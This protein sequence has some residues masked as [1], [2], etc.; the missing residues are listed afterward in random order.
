[1]KTLLNILLKIRRLYWRIVKPKT[2]GVRAILVNSDGKILL[3]RHKYGTGWFLPGGKSRRN[4]ADEIALARELSEE[5]GARDLQKMQKLGEYENKQEGKR[6][7]I[8]VF[9][10]HNFSLP[11]TEKKHFEIDQIVFFDPA[12]LPKETSPGTQ[13]RIAEWRGEKTIDGR[14]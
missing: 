7:T 8:V 6:D 13:R 10:I 9:M 1:M 4:E 11:R 5:L 3:V 14:W 2:R 12:S